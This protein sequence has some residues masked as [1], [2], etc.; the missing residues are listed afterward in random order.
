MN[1]IINLILQKRQQKLRE[2][3]CRPRSHSAGEWGSQVLNPGTLQMPLPR[4]SRSPG[5]TSQQRSVRCLGVG[6]PEEAGQGGRGGGTAP[7]EQGSVCQERPV[8]NTGALS[9]SSSF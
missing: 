9:Q 7:P 2:V 5:V 8:P 3:V 6:S 4:D 1:T